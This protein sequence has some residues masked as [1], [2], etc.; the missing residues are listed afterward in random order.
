[1]FLFTV[2]GSNVPEARR[3]FDRVFV[4]IILNRNLHRQRDNLVKE[5]HECF[6]VEMVGIK[7]ECGDPDET[8][9]R[10]RVLGLLSSLL[11]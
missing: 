8:R 11:V 10:L 3:R 9:C 4:T 6:E 1:M 7:A 2:I 5:S